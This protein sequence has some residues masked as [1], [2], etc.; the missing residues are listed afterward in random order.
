MRAKCKI[1]TEIYKEFAA[2]GGV[3][4]LWKTEWLAFNVSL[5]AFLCLRPCYLKL[6]CAVTQK[7]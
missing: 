5:D 7:P 1:L 2:E 4:F 3:T 6:P